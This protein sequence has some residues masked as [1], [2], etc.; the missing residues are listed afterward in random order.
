MI[1]GILSRIELMNLTIPL[2]INEN[3]EIVLQRGSLLPTRRYRLWQISSGVIKTSTCLEDGTNVI[4][5]IW[6]PGDLVGPMLSN[7]QP[8]TIDCLTQV[9]VIPITV[10]NHPPLTRLLLEHIRRA[11]ELTVIRSY[12][13]IELMLIKLLGWFA[14]KYGIERETGHL[15]DLRLTHQDLADILGATRVT[16]TRAL[17]QLEQQGMIER[18]NLGRIIVHEE[19]VWHY[20]I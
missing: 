15:I 7:I 6:G 12:R 4:L 9:N 5:G 17:A 1:T 16:I 20:Q 13:R 8:Y 2:Q 10:N 14:K 19:G 18:M 11:E 3:E